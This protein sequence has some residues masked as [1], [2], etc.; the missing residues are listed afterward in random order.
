MRKLLVGV[1]AL[2]PLL[3]LASPVEAARRPGPSS[4]SGKRDSGRLVSRS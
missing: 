2:V 1:T 4:A 3:T